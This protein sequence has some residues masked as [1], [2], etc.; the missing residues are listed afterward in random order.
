[1]ISSGLKIYL[2]NPSFGIYEFWIFE[3]ATSLCIF[4]QVFEG[5]PKS[6][7][8]NL[9]GAYL[10]T[11]ATFCENLMGEAID[12]VDSVN[13]RILYYAQ[14]DYIFALLLDKNVEDID[15]K[16]M[17]ERMYYLF[18]SKYRDRLGPAFDGDVSLFEDFAD[19]IETIFNMKTARFQQF[20]HTTT[21]R[22]QSEI[23]E[24]FD[25]HKRRKSRLKILPECSEKNESDD[26]P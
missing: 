5:L 11:L 22:L 21:E 26:L 16:E 1:M 6:V 17:L 23:T 14:T 4:E 8:S 25:D 12:R 10:V 3:K 18:V 20:L 15:A 2:V 19:E 9:I 24:L 13:M 7:D